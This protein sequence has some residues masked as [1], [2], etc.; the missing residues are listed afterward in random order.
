MNLFG[1]L[2]RSKQTF[3]SGISTLTFGQFRTLAFLA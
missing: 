2:L 1:Q 3:P